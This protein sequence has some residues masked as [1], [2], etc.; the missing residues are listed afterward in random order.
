MKDKLIN[1]QSNV[2]AALNDKSNSILDMFFVDKIFGIEPLS[3]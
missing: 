1:T 3:T 2:E